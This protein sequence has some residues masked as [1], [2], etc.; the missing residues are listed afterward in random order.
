M[1]TSVTGFRLLDGSDGATAHAR[2]QAPAEPGALSVSQLERWLDEIR[3]QPSWRREADKACDYYD[4]NQLDAETLA[5]LDEKGLGPLVTNLIQP[6]VNAV[7]GM[8]AKTR[9]DWRV[10][11]DDDR[12]QDVA[13]ALS[14]KMHETEREAQADTATSDAYASQIKAGFGVVE[15]SRN[16]NP[17]NYP[18]RVT[19]VPRSEIYW[20]WRSRTLDWSDAR[21]VVRKKRYDA[22]HIAAF[23]PEHREMIIA[24]ASWRDWAD[25]LTN[26]ARMSADFFNSLGQG[27]RRPTDAGAPARAG[28]RRQE[29]NPER[30]APSPSGWLWPCR[31]SGASCWWRHSVE[32]MGQV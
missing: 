11:A 12:Y 14:A 21:Y 30:P 15:V 29:P 7:L 26:E 20:D 9:T 27:T 1:N 24:A 19:S 6:T 5:R 13:E 22:D 3:D 28:G 32:R 17:F 16:S 25:Y 23:F 2:D 10:G 4:G 31:R 8:E 18:Y